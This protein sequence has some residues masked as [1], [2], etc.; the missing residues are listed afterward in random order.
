MLVGLWVL[1][2]VLERKE[3]GS[4]TEN[5][6]S[7]GYRRALLWVVLE[8]WPVVG[9]KEYT[10]ER[11][12][13]FGRYFGTGAVCSGGWLN[14]KYTHLVDVQLENWDFYEYPDYRPGT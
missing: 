12:D 13:G 14:G 11:A 3:N 5:A 1:G 2:L 7:V 9:R 8:D 10:V 4:D 6:H